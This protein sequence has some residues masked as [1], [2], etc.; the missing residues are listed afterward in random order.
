MIPP[1]EALPE[2]NRPS[3]IVSMT[4]ASRGNAGSK[5]VLR[6]L[7]RNSCTLRHLTLNHPQGCP[8][9]TLVRI[10]APVGA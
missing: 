8:A 10:R 4:L 5:P 6:A 7:V 9:L 1:A 3:I 2:K